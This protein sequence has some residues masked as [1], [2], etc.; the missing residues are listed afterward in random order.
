M[1]SPMSADLPPAQPE[2]AEQYFRRLAISWEQHGARSDA[3]ML[4]DLMREYD[5]RGEEIER[6][7]LHAGDTVQIY[8]AGSTRP[9]VVKLL[10]NLSGPLVVVPVIEDVR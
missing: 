10:W 1:S 2:T 5:R 7:A 6:P 3:K 8:D 9:A 4:V